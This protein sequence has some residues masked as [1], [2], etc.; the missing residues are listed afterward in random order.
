MSWRRA[1]SKLQFLLLRR[2]DDLSE[3]I[4]AHLAME[5]AEN[6]AAGMDREQAR[7]Q[8][9]RRFGNPMLS[10]ESSRDMWKWMATET[11]RMDI[12]YALRQLRHNPGFAAVAVLTLA[13]GVGANTAI[14]SVVNAVLLRPLPFADPD[15]LVDA[16]ETEEAP[17]TYPVNPADYLDWQAQNRTLEATSVYSWTSIASLAGPGEPASA[18]VTQVQA[19]FFGTLG[20]SPYL[21]R[22]FS[23]GEDVA[24][25]NHVALLSYA[26]WRRNFGGSTGTIGKTVDLNAERYT[27]VGVM[28]PTFHFPGT[29][30][31][32][33]P[34]DMTS[35]QF[36]Q[37]GNHGLNVIGRIKRNVTLAQAR[38]DLLAISLR[39]EK[40]FP[41]GNT[42]VHAVLFSLKDRLVGGA[43]ERLLVLLATVALVL[44]IACV[45]VANLLLARAA[46]RQREIALRASLGAG[47]LRMIRQLLTESL[48]LSFGG[49]AL[50]GLGAWWCVR[51]LN[52]VT[53]PFVPDLNP[54]SIDISVL[55]FTLGI[56]L[57]AALLFGLAPALQ[58][59]RTEVSDSL[60]AAAQAVVGSSSVRQRLRDALIVSEIAITLALLVGA[61]LLLRSF[62]KLQNA[63]IGVDPRNL[64]TASVNL[65]D[66]NYP[67]LAAR[68][69]FFD[70]LLER[71]RRIPGV[72]AAAIST[73]IPLEGGS[74]G[75]IHVEGISDPAISST[76]IG[77]NYV[78]P[79]YFKT[80]GVPFVRGRAF[81]AEDLDHDAAAS[82][83]IYELYLASGNAAKI[84]TDVTLCA[85]I[86]KTA[87]RIFWKGRDPLGGAFRWNGTKVVV[88]GIVDDVKEYGIRAKTMA[89]AYFPFTAALPYD[90][91]ANLTLKTAITPT[92]VLG[93]LRRNLHTLDRGLALLRPR[94]MEEVIDSDTQDARVET[95]LLGAFAALAL[96]LA[97]VG[98]YG[99][100]SY[101]VTQRTREIGIRMAVGANR[102]D[103]LGMILRQG[104]GLTLVG[105]IAGLLLAGALSRS[106]AGLLFG[107]SPFDAFTFGGTAA[108]LALVATAA[109]AVPARR[110]AKIDPMLALRYE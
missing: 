68:R 57:L 20:I 107:T 81:N 75:Y 44:L 60:K 66:A 26:F 101:T 21:G 98:L 9:K 7:H 46:A 22:S 109:Y 92:A 55:L 102:T 83:K 50:G 96:V 56:S 106:I 12:A 4:G 38:Q 18:A 36:S 10:E 34:I 95:V 103:V 105:V 33:V 53:T 108:L 78:T 99:V 43:Q 49:A 27:I 11:L 59:S 19:N 8:A 51:L 76:L 61:G 85:V 3:E 5:E 73:E 25:R 6:V 97:A 87:A 63:G 47:R 28:P 58:L 45:N 31:V 41:D 91:Y 2:P 90:E 100:M 94:T 54:V 17:G 39:L 14:F 64:L 71:T 88:V 16:R 72:E 86:S 40:Q 23:K 29:T 37:R 77:F 1:L 70:Q 30:E 82:Q 48:V 93:D 52:R 13:L 24:G 110:A 84:P 69:Q 67:G 42:K 62:V 74:N 79:D 32:W 89:Q 104:L 35:K 15:R 80:F 65:P